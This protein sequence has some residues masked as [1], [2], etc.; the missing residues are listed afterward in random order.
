MVVMLRVLWGKPYRLCKARGG[1]R[2]SPGVEVYKA[3]FRVSGRVL[4]APLDAALRVLGPF[5]K[6]AGV[7][8]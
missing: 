6:A 4:R 8:Q 5:E 3:E 2:R 7:A 1:L